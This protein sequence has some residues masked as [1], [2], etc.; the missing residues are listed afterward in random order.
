MHQNNIPSLPRLRDENYE[1][2]FN[3][4]VDKDDFYFYNLLQTVHFPQT[5][6]DNYFEFYNVK[7]NDTW[8]VISYKFYKKINLWWLIAL[9]NNVVD[10]INSLIVGSILKIPKPQV[11]TEILTQIVTK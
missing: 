3:V 1:N 2:I 8:P 10:P 9:A 5:L 7:Y 4:Y 6:P 11:V